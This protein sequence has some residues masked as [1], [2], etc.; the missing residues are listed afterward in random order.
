MQSKVWT[1]VT[2]IAGFALLALPARFAEAQQK[3]H[4]PLSYYVFNLGDPGGGTSAAAASINNIGWIAGN[5]FQPGNSTEH[6]ELWIGTPV[7][8]GTF[9][10]PNSAVAWPNKNTRGEIAGIAETADLNPLNEAWSCAEANFPTITNHVCLGFLWKDGV[11]SALPPLPGGIDSYA[12]GT[13]NRG[14]IAGWAENGVHDPTCD[15]SP[16]ASQF[17]QF[18]A[19]VWGP[20]LGQMTQLSPFASDPD[21]AATAINDKGQVVGISGLCSNAVGGTS[22][23]HAVLWQNGT[24]MNLG[25]FDGGIAWNTPT[26]I[27]NHTQVVGFGNLPNTPN[28]NFNPVAFLWTREHGIRELLPI[29]DDSNSWAW[30]ISEKGVVVGESFG[31]ADDPFGRAFIYQN[32]LMTDLNTLTQPNSSLHLIL[33]NDINDAGEIVGFAIDTNTSAIVAF[34]AV[35]VKDGSEREAS[36]AKRGQGNVRKLVLPENL[37]LQLPGAFSRFARGVAKAY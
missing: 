7:D 11:M 30:G 5:A 17:L 26:A 19:V 28:A 32:G 13:N 20:E 9:G 25:N 16:P 12:A 18:E 35:P 8:L 4:E 14:Q 1:F 37:R 23:E 2:A 33:A 34:L 3:P 21:S 29:G 15:N 36:S 24:P 6:A 10:G 22:A 31:G 27:N